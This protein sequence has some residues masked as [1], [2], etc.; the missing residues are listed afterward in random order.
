MRTWTN[1]NWPDDPY[2]TGQQLYR[3]R[4]HML[5]A[6]AVRRAASG[7]QPT[8][9][10]AAV[11]YLPLHKTMMLAVTEQTLAFGFRAASIGDAAEAPSLAAMADLDL[12]QA[13]RHAA[14]LAGHLLLADLTALRRGAGSAPMRGLA[15]V[16]KAWA[17]R[18][19]PR[20]GMAMMIDAAADLPAAP[21]LGE[22]C[23]QARIAFAAGRCWP[24]RAADSELIAA[25]AVERALVI[26]LICAR[27][28]GRYEW[29]SALS[30]G[31]IMTAQAWDCFPELAPGSPAVRP[32][33]VGETAS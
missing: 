10:A 24:A 1:M 6:F 7:C 20:R 31:A 18:Q 13:R 23:H 15:A 26:A 8:A 11:V 22:A 5:A 16:E 12:L 29:D 2:G 33:P 21:G 14:V 30:S 9:T 17:D 19:T 32:A 27:H 4:S 25:Q 3:R 28:L